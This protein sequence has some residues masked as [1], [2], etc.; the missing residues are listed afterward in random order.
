MGAFFFFWLFSESKF[1]FNVELVC[2]FIIFF[3]SYY[4]YF[5]FLINLV[6]FA[7]SK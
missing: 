6:V 2:F 3:M 4:C 1:I 5:K 7:F